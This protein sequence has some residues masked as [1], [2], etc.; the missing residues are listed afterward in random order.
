MI[1][2]TLAV[3]VLV[4]AALLLLVEVS[5][6]Q[7]RGPMV[8]TKAFADADTATLFIFGRNFHRNAR[9]FFGTEDGLQELANPIIT[10]STIIVGLPTTAPGTYLFVV[11]I[12]Q[13]GNQM[14]A[15]DVTIG[16]SILSRICR[17]LRAM[18]GDLLL[19]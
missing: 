16:A 3:G 17:T 19:E 6:A 10:D 14:R 4:F 2:R 7:P 12:G 8:V 15:M 1:Q 13:G 18:G 11:R 5:Y 9:V